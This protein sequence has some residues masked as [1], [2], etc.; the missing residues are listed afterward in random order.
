MTTACLTVTAR[1]ERSFQVLAG[2]ETLLPMVMGLVRDEVIDLARAFALMAANPARL[3]GVEAGMLEPGLEADLALVD[4]DKPWVVSS[5]KMAASAG[6][7]P[8]DGQPVQG[9]TLALWKGGMRIEG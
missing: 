3:L 5:A 2:A 4:P 6:N 1:D 8:F 9:R 7:T